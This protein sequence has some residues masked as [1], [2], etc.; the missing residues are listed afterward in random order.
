MMEL[1]CN[2]EGLHPLLFLARNSTY[3]VARSLGMIF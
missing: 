3:G 1:G 2:F